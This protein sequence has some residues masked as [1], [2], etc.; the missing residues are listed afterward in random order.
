MVLG[1][2]ARSTTLERLTVTAVPAMRI[3]AIDSCTV[4]A[5]QTPLVQLPL[6]QS[7]FWLQGSPMFPGT[8]VLEKRA[9]AKPWQHSVGRLQACP[10]VLH[11]AGAA[12]EPAEQVSPAQHVIDPP[13]DRPELAHEAG[14]TQAPAVQ[15]FFAG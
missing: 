2:T 8:H 6:W 12:Q 10:S 1:V 7:L 9:Q 13:H 15:E 11:V 5:V 14:A 3:A 4:G